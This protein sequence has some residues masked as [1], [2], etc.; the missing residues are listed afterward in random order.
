MCWRCHD[1]VARVVVVTIDRYY[2][3]VCSA[4]AVKEV[5]CGGYYDNNYAKSDAYNDGDC[6]QRVALE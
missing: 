5:G 4:A 1:D 3:D 2:N 6:Q